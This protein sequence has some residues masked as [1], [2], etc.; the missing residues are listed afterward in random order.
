M[1]GPLTRRRE[2]RILGAL[3]ALGSLTEYELAEFLGTRRWLLRAPLL[4]L[5][6]AGQITAVKEKSLIGACFIWS[7]RGQEDQIDG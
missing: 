5:A 2:R 3:R 6:Q 4:N 1:R 7:I